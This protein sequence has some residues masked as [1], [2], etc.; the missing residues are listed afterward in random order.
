VLA[1]RDGID[2]ARRVPLVE[3][4]HAYRFAA[5]ELEQ[6]VGLLEGWCVSPTW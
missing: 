3:H 6:A 2:P 4:A 5:G 1:A